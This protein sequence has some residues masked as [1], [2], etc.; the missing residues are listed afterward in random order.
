MFTETILE[1]DLSVS[2]FLSS[3]PIPPRERLIFPLDV[4]THAEAKKLV[5][6]LGDSVIFYKLGLQ[7]FMAQSNY[8]ELVDWLNEHGKKVFV[9]LKFYDIPE[10]VGSAVY[11]M[12]NM[13]VEFV[14]V[15]GAD[16]NF[17]AAVKEKNGIKILAVT[18]LT[19]L[20]QTDLDAM[21][22]KCSLEELV[23]SRA[24]RALDLGC[25]GVISSGLEASKL[26]EHLGDK[27]LIISPGIRPLENRRID[28]Q[29]RIM[30][31]EQA[32]NSGADYIVMG[33]P[34][35]DAAN[36]KAEAENVQ[37]RIAKLFEH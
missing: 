1:Q 30:T 35:R 34:I 19:S 6:E 32:F 28:D 27:F 8:Y 21:G 4:A 13:R 26:R 14:T 10:T 11:Q 5:T 3:K 24:K 33:R 29:K 12:R 2:S 7:L 18:V 15:H 37:V 20:D 17:E 36:P 16:A 31:V 9:D 25:S 23:L 22:F